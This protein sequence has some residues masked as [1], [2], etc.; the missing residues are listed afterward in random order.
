MTTE[1]ERIVMPLRMTEDELDRRINAAIQAQPR[2]AV[3]SNFYLQGW[4]A[5]KLVPTVKAMLL[6][7]GLVELIVAAN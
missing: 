6:E 5:A 3:N 1:L 2:Y 7:V 4:D